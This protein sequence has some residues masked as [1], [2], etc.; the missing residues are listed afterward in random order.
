MAEVG[1][2]HYLPHRPVIREDKTTTKIRA[3]FDASCKVNGPSLNECLYSGPNLL[4]IL[5]RFR[6]NTIA[7][8][9]D[10]KQAF[11][12]VAISPEHRDYL[13]FLWYD[14]NSE[15]TIVYKFSRV[16]FGLTSSPFLRYIES[17]HIVLER[18]NKD[19]YVDDL[20]SGS[21]SLEEAKELYDRSNS[22]MLE[23]GFDLRKWKPIITNFKHI[24]DISRRSQVRYL[25]PGT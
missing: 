25:T 16:V 3:V 22:I 9:A 24:Y 5:I 19:L 1:K 4:D 15:E 18:L 2:V 6:F 8:M 23:A 21:N 12:N 17:E 13:R 10:I 20:V 7:I 14:L 11:L